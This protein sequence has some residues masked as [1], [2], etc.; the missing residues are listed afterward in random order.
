MDPLETN[1][2]YQN[3]RPHGEPQ[4][5]RRGLYSSIG[6]GSEGRERQLALLWVLNLSDGGH[7]LLAVAERSG[8]PFPRVREAAAALLEAELLELMEEEPAE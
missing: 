1:R 3:P 7:D 5:G 2:A 4:L 8:L 6:G